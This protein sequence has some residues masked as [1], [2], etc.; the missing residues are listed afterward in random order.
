MHAVHR[1][2]TLL[3]TSSDPDCAWS[4]VVLARELPGPPLVGT[5]SSEAEALRLCEALSPDLLVIDSAMMGSP[6]ALLA[7]IRASGLPVEPA[8]LVMA[9]PEQAAR[10]ADLLR[11]AG[12]W[13]VL[14]HDA[15]PAV[16]LDR[17]NT[18]LHMHGRYGEVA[19]RVSALEASI[20]DRNQ[21][22]TEAL[23][24]L[25]QAE[26]HVASLQRQPEPESLPPGSD[27][28]ASVAHE[29]RTP[30][31][32]I[33]GFA[34]L[35]RQEVYGPTG[36]PRYAEYA[37]DIHEAANHL[38]VLVNGTLDLSRMANGQEQLEIG[39][40]DIGRTIHDATRLL[41]QMADT[42][43]VRLVVN[44]P[45]HIVKIRTDPD[46]VRQI[47][48]NLASNAIKFTPRG[49]QVTVEVKAAPDGGA[50]ILVIR[51]TGIGMAANDI[52]TAMKPF[53]QIRRSDHPAPKGTGLGL[54]LTKRFVEMLG[55]TLEILS[56]VGRGTMVVVRLPVASAQSQT[57]PDHAGALA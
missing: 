47:I 31:H 5:F 36:D 46:K 56:Q 19:E 40:V 26:K 1:A 4:T 37:N 55:G 7:Q 13:D 18:L 41:R 3:T 15:R 52:P 38:L 17:L 27:M 16:V 23:A 28:L 14:P 11:R 48:V 51:D 54:P 34:D 24:L 6:L 32:A 35:I 21:R 43:G 42:G 2:A 49:G 8:I 12:A 22:L 44:L 20:N 57:T 30:L 33:I 45:D 9:P 53:G 10:S 50:V 25:H 39:D 29:L